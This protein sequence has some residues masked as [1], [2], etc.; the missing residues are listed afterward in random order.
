MVPASFYPPFSLNVVPT[1]RWMTGWQES[2]RKK[3]WVGAYPYWVPFLLF[4]L[5]LFPTEGMP[6]HE[7]PR[8][9]FCQD[10]GIDWWSSHDIWDGSPGTEVFWWCLEE[11]WTQTGKAVSI[12]EAP[13]AQV[14]SRH[15]QMQASLCLASCAG[16]LSAFLLSPFFFFFF[17]FLYPSSD[18]S[19]HLSVSQGYKLGTQATIAS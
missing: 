14:S 11:G 5:I 7:R 1:W 13:R 4:V 17:L 16:V 19:I 12:L 18:W 15:K 3:G 9:P 8:P 10:F 6:R 2:Y